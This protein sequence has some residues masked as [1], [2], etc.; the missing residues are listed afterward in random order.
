LATDASDFMLKLWKLL[1][2]AQESTGGIPQEF[3]E[4]K[5]EE[6]RA[7]KAEQERIKTELSKKHG[8]QDFIDSNVRYY[9]LFYIAN[10]I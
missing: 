8:D 4:Q 6:I 9:F 2:S 1:I 7:R 3:L 10:Y 5:K